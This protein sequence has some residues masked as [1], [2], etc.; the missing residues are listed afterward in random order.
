VSAEDV[1]EVHNVPLE[2]I[3]IQVDG[4]DDE[5]E[6]IFFS[7]EYIEE[8]CIISLYE[9]EKDQNGHTSPPKKKDLGYT[10]ARVTKKKS[11]DLD[12]YVPSS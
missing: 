6:D 5:N 11:D 1:G 2:T 9:K 7:F 4:V 8:L 12:T 10:C 3:L